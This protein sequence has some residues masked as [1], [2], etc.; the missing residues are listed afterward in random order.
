[1]NKFQDRKKFPS[2]QKFNPFLLFTF[3]SVS[4]P[5]RA[6][7]ESF[8]SYC[9]AL[10]RPK[11]INRTNHQQSSCSIHQK[12]LRAQHKFLC[13][14]TKCTQL[15]FNDTVLRKMIA[16]PSSFVQAWDWHCQSVIK[17]Q[18]QSQVPLAQ[19]LL[20]PNRN[21]AAISNVANWARAKCVEH[22]VCM[23]VGQGFEARATPQRVT[24]QGLSARG[25]LLVVMP[26]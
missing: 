11:I 2:S 10:I 18:Y 24:V 14:E 7:F 13:S 5:N 4:E 12:P 25:P 1:M 15:L 20:L 16:S 8:Q 21:K 9:F 19:S 26:E 6:R 17:Q 3:F 22:S 23:E